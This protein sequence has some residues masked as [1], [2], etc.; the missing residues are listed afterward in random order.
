M[1]YLLYCIF[2]SS[3]YQKRE[4]ILGVESQPVF[5]VTNNG[6][7]AAISGISDS[8]LVPDISPALVY[9]KVI[10]SFH[11]ERTVIPMRYGCLFEEE[12]QV[13]Q[14]LK[15]RCKQYKTLLRRLEGC[16]E[17]GIRI[18]L[19]GEAPYSISHFSTDLAICSPAKANL[20][21]TGT[22]E[23]PG[24]AYLTAQTNRYAVKD[25]VVFEQS[26]I[27]ERICSSLSD[28]FVQSKKGSRLLTRN[29]LLSLYF[30]V[31]R[32]SVQLFRKAFRQINMKGP[33]K[34][35]L[36]GPWPPYNF[37]LSAHFQNQES[38]HESK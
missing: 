19:P 26:M 20:T 13:I 37:V 34:L 18:L 32:S 17:M 29:H 11:R 38:L 7:S 22:V 28:L 12:S 25:R 27:M 31:P 16:V 4:A 21:L 33:A 14:L 30:L 2:Q 36:S 23:N 3:E 10:E 1:R 24:R 8:D 35:L 9:E 5:L 15:E 6:L